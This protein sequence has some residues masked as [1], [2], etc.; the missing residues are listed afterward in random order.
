[1]TLES[2]AKQGHATLYDSLAASIGPKIRE[3]RKEFIQECFSGFQS[4]EHRLE[5]VAVIH[6]MEFI[7]DSK[8]SNINSTWFALENTHRP[9]VWIVGGV[10]AGNDYGIIRN[11]VRRKVKG[12][13]CLGLNNERIHEAFD[14]LGLP[15]T[16][17]TSMEG[18]VQSAYYMGE[19]GDIILLSPACASFD[20]FENYEERGKA[21][22]KAVKNL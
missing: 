2:L 5:T 13:V 6:G 21:F 22:R 19:V 7:N 1:M 17:V 4:V 12:I 9:V 20:L 18:A 8:S 16:D 11:L 10:E 3:I 15:M 14:E